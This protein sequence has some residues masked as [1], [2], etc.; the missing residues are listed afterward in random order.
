MTRFGDGPLGRKLGL[1]EVIEW[2]P[3]LIGLVHWYEEEET[4][5]ISPYTHRGEATLGRGEKTAVCKPESR[6]PPETKPAGTSIVDFQPP[7][8]EKETSFV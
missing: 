3:D 6:P 1:N 5:E 4:P 8:C 7:D 2:D